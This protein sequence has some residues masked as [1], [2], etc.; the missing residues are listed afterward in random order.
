MTAY[1]A[2]LDDMA[3]ALTA[4]RRWL[5]EV[6]EQHPDMDTSALDD[7]LRRHRELRSGE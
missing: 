7:L 2:L 6:A 1:D 3:S 5:M 4:L